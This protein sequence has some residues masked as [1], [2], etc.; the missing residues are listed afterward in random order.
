MVLIFNKFFRPYK[1][2]MEGAGSLFSEVTVFLFTLTLNLIETR[3]ITSTK[4]KLKKLIP[5]D[6]NRAPHEHA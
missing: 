2:G 5:K 3:V 4:K 1:P 6:F